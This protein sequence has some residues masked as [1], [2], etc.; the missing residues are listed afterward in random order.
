MSKTITITLPEEVVQ[1]FRQ[2][3]DE[4][5]RS[6]EDVL[7]E[8]LINHQP[9]SYT[10]DD[11]LE[12]LKDFNDDVLW[13]VVRQSLTPEQEQRLHELTGILKSGA[14]LTANEEKEYQHLHQ[15]VMSQMLRRSAALVHLKERGYDVS[16]FFRDNDE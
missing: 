15:T 1:S 13:A 11:L 6:V 4:D 8:T 12:S 5:N 16:R 2:I 7:V 10:A 14:T 3:A 9:G